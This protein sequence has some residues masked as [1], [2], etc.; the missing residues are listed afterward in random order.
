MPRVKRR[1]LRGNV[2]G[3]TLSGLAVVL[4]IFGATVGVMQLTTN[5]KIK[6]QVKTLAA[7]TTA[8]GDPVVPNETKPVAANTPVYHAAADEPRTLTIDKIKVDAHIVG[9]GVKA[10]GEL[11]TPTNIYDVGWYKGSAKPGDLGAIL[12][13]GHVHGPTQPGVFVGLKKLK[14]GDKITIKRGDGKMFTYHVVKTQSYAKDAVD[15]GAA[16]SSAVPGKP[17]LNM[18]TCDG[19]YDSAGEYDNRLIVFAVQE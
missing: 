11:K 10:D 15:M 3:M 7:Q 17:G 12:L 8:T 19:T 4:F 1:V 14:A 5:Q 13:D 18:I 6:A 2:W 16:F 9:V